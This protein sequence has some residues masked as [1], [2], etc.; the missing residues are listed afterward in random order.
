MVLGGLIAIGGVISPAFLHPENLGNILVQL[1]P[2]GVATIGQTFVILV[3][4]LDLSVGSVMATAAVMA[5]LFPSADISVAGIVPA[6]IVLGLIVG[7]V[8]G[9]LVAWRDVSPFLAT[10]A[11]MVVLIGVRLIVTHGAPSANL[12]PLLHVI[13]TGGVL[14]I[15]YAVVILAVMGIA[16][17]VL[18]HRTAFGRH[19]L[20]T[21]GSPRAAEL[22]GVPVR[23]IRLAC[24][25]LSG[26]I[27]ALA[28]VLLAGYVGLMDNWVGRG[29]ELDTI[30]AAVIGGVALSGGRGTIGGAVAGAAILIV[31]SNI[32]LLLGMPIQGQVIIRGV[33][34]VLGATAYRAAKS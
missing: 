21:G 4:G 32:V 23:R 17:A 10:L 2:L 3:G 9:W 26:M 30:V 15:P 12:P 22:V 18:V 28:G 29:Y 6:A 16:A 1:A 11:T 13:G 24:Y 14:G 33:V 19:V 34:V 8:N 5:T 7:A 25:M 31:V 27:A 20:M